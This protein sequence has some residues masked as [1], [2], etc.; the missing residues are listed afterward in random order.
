MIAVAITLATR[1]EQ[2]TQRL[3]LYEKCHLS[4]SFWNEIRCHYNILCNFVLKAD[5]VLSPFILV[6]SFSNMFFICQKIFTQFENNRAP[7]ERYYSYYSSIFLI[8]RTIGML[9]FGASV[10]E[11]SRGTLK[12]LR[13]VPTQSFSGQD[14]IID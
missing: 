2:L 5:K 9:C 7:W 14:V 13:E 10:N 4:E 11:K 3:K 12:I 8:S 6:Y 1:F